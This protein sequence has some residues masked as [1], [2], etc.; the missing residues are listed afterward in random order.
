MGQKLLGDSRDLFPNDMALS[1]SVAK[2]SRPFMPARD[3]AV[4]SYRYVS[5][6][7]WMVDRH[8]IERDGQPS[9]LY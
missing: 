6:F 9:F 4:R 3:G 7:A 2:Q 8:L 5:A 1:V